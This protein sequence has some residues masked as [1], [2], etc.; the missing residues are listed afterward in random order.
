M[1]KYLDKINNDEKTN[2]DNI[3]DE[4]PMINNET[5]EALIASLK[6]SL[7]YHKAHPEI[8]RKEGDIRT[9]DFYNLVEKTIREVEEED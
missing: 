5:K 2:W 3:K 6:G 7:N 9:E 8:E 4:V 1:E